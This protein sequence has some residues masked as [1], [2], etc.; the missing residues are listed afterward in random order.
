M[1]IKITESDQFQSINYIHLD[2]NTQ[3]AA[4]LVTIAADLTGD[5]ADQFG[6]VKA[7]SVFKVTGAAIEYTTLSLDNIDRADY[8]GDGAQVIGGIAVGG[9]VASTS[10]ALLKKVVSKNPVVWTTSTLAGIYAAEETDFAL[11]WLNRV[12]SDWNRNPFELLRKELSVNNFDLEVGDLVYMSDNL[13]GEEKV[14]VR[15]GSE[16]ISLNNSLEDVLNDNSAAIAQA[17]V[18]N[19]IEARFGFGEDSDT[20]YQ[21]QSE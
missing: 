12:A 11:N 20:I 21:R 3:D 4:K 5:A 8:I 14:Y 1:L 10:A 16:I 6:V 15:R 9:A 13:P 17:M 19:D 2:Q 7:G 18:F